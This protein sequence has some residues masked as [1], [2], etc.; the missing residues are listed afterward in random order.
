V[1]TGLV[2]QNAEKLSSVYTTGGLSG[3]QTMLH[4]GYSVATGNLG[5]LS[6]IAWRE[7]H[8]EQTTT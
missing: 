1:W 2:L 3:S 6:V 7:E 4:E 8:R 5:A